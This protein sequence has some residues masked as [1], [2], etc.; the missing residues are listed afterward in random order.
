M[1]TTGCRQAYFIYQ[2]T[3]VKIKTN[4][5][6]NTSED[7]PVSGKINDKIDVCLKIG[8]DGLSIILKGSSEWSGIT[9]D[10]TILFHSMTPEN[11]QKL[12]VG[13]RNW[14]YMFTISPQDFVI[15]RS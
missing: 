12:M 10:L 4:Y 5:T 11:T 14:S 1:S 8:K 7:L 9:L 3:E 6:L 2:Y 15:F 13:I